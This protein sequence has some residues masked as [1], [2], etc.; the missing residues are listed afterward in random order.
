MLENL[1]GEGDDLHVVLAAE[2]AG[3]RAEDAGALRVAVL[4]DD[5]DALESKAE[6]AAVGAAQG[7]AGAD[8]NGLDDLALLSRWRRCCFP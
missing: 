1:R 8:D 5:D 3:D 6:V 2:F 4:A 7:G